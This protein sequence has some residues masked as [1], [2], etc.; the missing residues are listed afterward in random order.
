MAVDLGWG[1]DAVDVRVEQPF[2]NPGP[3]GTN[4][5]GIVGMQERARLLGGRFSAGPDDS[6][7]FVVT[8]SL[9]YEN[10]AGEA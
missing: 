8:A 5:L 2:T 7:L 3:A 4:G 1:Q 9:P 6:G 10:G